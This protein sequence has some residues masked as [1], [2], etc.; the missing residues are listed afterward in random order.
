MCP[1]GVFVFALTP[2]SMIGA[3]AAN[4]NHCSFLEIYKKNSQSSII[5]IV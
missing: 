3:E 2:H 4:N 1:I 5:L